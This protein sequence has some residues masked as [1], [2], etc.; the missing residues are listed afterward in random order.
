LLIRDLRFSDRDMPD[1]PRVQPTSRAAW[2]AWLQKHHA[3]SA[4]VWLVYAKKQS[5]IPSL[6]YNDAVEEALCFGWIDNKLLP[7]DD[8]LFMQAFTPRKPKS[9][10]S[11]LNKTRV[12][13]VIAAG[14]MTQA[15]LDA[16]AVAKKTGTWTA[17]DHVE[18]L[19]VP[20][21]FAKAL[22]TTPGAQAAF[23]ALTPGKKKQ[24]LY[25]LNDAKK[26]ETRTNRIAELVQR[27]T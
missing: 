7:I 1:H 10:W 22:K 20:P 3:T 5:G 17:L 21:D 26:P 2:R 12:K 25:Y 13:R 9:R 11:A 19:T 16:I 27:L 8:D 6:T 4:G 23:D 15:G 18:A 24:F 14:L